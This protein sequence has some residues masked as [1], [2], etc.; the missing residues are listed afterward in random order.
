[1]IRSELREPQ[2]LTD[3]GVSL[4]LGD[5]G[6]H[7]VSGIVPPVMEDVQGSFELPGN[8]R[9]GPPG[10]GSGGAAPASSGLVLLQ[11]LGLVPTLLNG[12]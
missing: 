3:G 4:Y 8:S 2:Y 1:M 6:L 5:G 9:S 11:G 10:N 12:D 7:A